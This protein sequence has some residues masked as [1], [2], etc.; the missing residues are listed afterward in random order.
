VLPQQKVRMYCLGW[1]QEALLP[2]ESVIWMRGE[3]W[4]KRGRETN[5]VLEDKEENRA[6]TRWI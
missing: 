2:S 5:C 6:G 4:R 1:T 3:E